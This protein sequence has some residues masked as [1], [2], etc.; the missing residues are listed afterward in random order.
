MKLCIFNVK[1]SPNLGDGVIADCLE[2][3]LRRHLPGA[4]IQSCDLAGRT[5]FG[6]GLNRSRALAMRTL[7]MTPGPLRKLAVSTLLRRLT[8]TRLIPHYRSALEGV[9]AVVLG[10]GQL[11]ADADLN[12]PIKIDAAMTEA[13]KAG[14][15]VSVYGVGVSK[16]WSTEGR[17]LF[18][19]AL[20]ADLTYVG[21]RD[22]A[23]AE[24]WQ[25]HFGAAVDA[26]IRDPGVLAERTYGPVVRPA[27][28]RPLIGL[29]IAH[30]STLKLHADDTGMRSIN[31]LDVF[32]KLARRLIDMGY[33]IDVFTNGA[34]DDEDFAAQ[35]VSRLDDAQS[36]GAVTLAPPPGTPKA[37]SLRIAGYDGLIA[38]RLHANIVAYAYGVPHV[39]LGWDAK[40]PAFF[41]S[42]DRSAYVLGGSDQTPGTIA[43][44]LADALENPISDQAR[45][46]VA[47]AADA[48]IAALA[49][50]LGQ[51]TTG[52]DSA[53]G[54]RALH[55]A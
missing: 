27:R 10:G 2:A 33:D 50:R 28:E 4:D 44:A 41:A 23:S 53:D 49:E 54:A 11:L 19:A 17:R 35:I 43:S 51:T 5:A 13:R 42:V 46:Q 30:P 37:L 26:V 22:R 38:H 45:A 9:D 32:Q 29:G 12:F 31:Y 18:Q 55:D 39:G 48:E 1:Y 3:A 34:H 15:T 47:E 52:P 40:M 20:G 25:T 21:V 36:G 6:E 24:N 16:R 8:D 7:D 14:A